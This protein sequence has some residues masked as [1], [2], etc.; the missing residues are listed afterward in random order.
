MFLLVT[1]LFT[2]MKPMNYS[3]SFGWVTFNIVLCYSITGSA[4]CSFLWCLLPRAMRTV[5][6]L[7]VT[8]L[9]SGLCIDKTATQAKGLLV[10]QHTAPFLPTFLLSCLLNS[11]SAPTSWYRSL[12]TSWVTGY[13]VSVP[14]V[15]CLS[16]CLGYGVLFWVGSGSTLV[17]LEQ[18][19]WQN[20]VQQRGVLMSEQWVIKA[21][22][23]IVKR[24]RSTTAKQLKIS[25]WRFQALL[26]F[27]FAIASLLC[28]VGC[29]LCCDICC[30]TNVCMLKQFFQEM[31]SLRVAPL[32]SCSLWF[33]CF[34]ELQGDAIFYYKLWHFCFQFSG[35][36]R[37]QA[38]SL[39]MNQAKGLLL[40]RIKPRTVTESNR[41]GLHSQIL[42]I[43]FIRSGHQRADRQVRPKDLWTQ[44]KLYHK[45]IK[46]M[47]F[48]FQKVTFGGLYLLLF[49]NLMQTMWTFE[50]LLTVNQLK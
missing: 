6:L 29:I 33:S 14:V 7:H 8:F 26:E 23:S 17:S 15:Q 32:C 42:C 20:T 45:E 1:D 25:V 4:E 9:K 34:L 38:C 11:R 19:I 50:T 31:W 44:L 10:F 43:S 3:G 35:G 41:F 30:Y 37:V 46:F 48:T 27:L 47:W 5:N 16:C 24:K 2:W 36:S 13:E 40:S 18:G 28:S 21:K 12:F 22:Q 49:C 39:I